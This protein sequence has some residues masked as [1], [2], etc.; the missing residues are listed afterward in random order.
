VRNETDRTDAVANITIA[1]N[2]TP[3]A[4][5]VI[6]TTGPEA[7]GLVN[8]F[9]VQ[10]AGPM[11][12]DFN[13]KSAPVGTLVTVTGTNLQP[14]AG[15]SA[16]VTLANQ[17]GGTL[18]GPVSGTTATSLSFVIPAGAAT[19]ALSVTVN[20]LSAST[21]VPMTIVP[22]STFT[23]SALPNPANL[24]LGQ[25][26]VYAVSLTSNGGFNQ[27]AALS[28]T[29]LPSGITAAF[30]PPQITGGQ[31]SVLSVTA[32]AGQPTGSTPL[33]VSAS[34]TVNGIAVVQSA[35][36]TLNVQPE[37]TSLLG[38]TVVSDALETPLAGV[39]ITMLGKDGNGNTTSCS[40]RTISD[41]AG[42]F[43]LTNLPAMCVGPQ[44]VGYD[45][46]TATS[47]SGKYAGV[48]LVYT[49][50]SGQA[51][52][53][54]VLIHLPRI[55]NQE[56]FLVQQ[57]E[58]VDQSYSYKTIPNLSVTAYAGTTF[59]MP[60]GTQPNP[61]P[62]TAVNVPVDRLPDIKPPV[63]TMI[64]AFI[65]AF[66]PAN[67]TTNQPVAVYYP[68]ELNEPAGMDMALLTLDPTH[69]AMVPYGTG[70]VSAD[71]SQIVP[72]L[73][74]AHSGHRY[75]LVHFD[76]HMPGYPPGNQLNPCVFCP[77]AKKGKPVDL[78]S[79]LEVINETDISFGG[80]RG[81]VSLVRTYRNA[82]NPQAT[83]YGPFGI[84][85]NHNYNYELGVVTASA[86]SVIPLILP[87]GNQLPFSKQGNGT[88]V[89]SSGIPSMAG[90]VMT[91][92]S[93]SNAVDLR[94]K[95][96]T[97]FRF[98]RIQTGV[99]FRNMLS[100][101]TDP[102]GNTIQILRN[103]FLVTD[104]ID[105][106][107]RDLNFSYNGD[108]FITQI[109]APDGLIVTYNYGSGGIFSERDVLRVV[110]HPDGTTTRY[111][112]DPSNNLT[113]VTDGRGVVIASNTYD[114]NNRVS[115]QRQANGGVLQFSYMVQNPTAPAFSP[116]L[117][118]TVTDALNKQTVYRFSPA[119]ALLGVTDPLG[120][121][122]VF[123]RDGSNNIIS[124]TGAAACE[125]CGSSGAGNQSFSYDGFGNL[126]SQTDALGNTTAFTYDP[127]F[128]KVTSIKDPLGDTTLFTYDFGGN[129][130]TQKDPNGNL[131]TYQYD[132]FGELKQA[133][134]PTNQTTFFSYDTFGNRI[135]IKD[136]LGD[137]TSFQY[138]AS[139]RLITT[140]DALNRRTQIAYDNADRIISQTNAQNAVTGFA[141]D[142][143][144]N[145]L[146]VTDPR[147]SQTTF[148]YDA[149]DGLFMRKDPLGR[150]DSR[151][152][153]LDEN[154]LQF[155]DRR[156]QTS[157]F[158]YDTT[159]RLTQEAYQDGTTV[160]RSY[161]ANNR[162]AGV[163]DSASGSFG[164]TYDSAGRVIGCTTPFGTMQY[165]RDSL[166]RATSRQVVGQPAVT[167]S[168]DKAGNLLT[169]ATPAASVTRT[170]EARNLLSTASRI[171]GVSSRYTYDQIGRLISLT[172]SGPGGILNTQT[173]SYDA[174]GNRQSATNTI[175]QTLV[176]PAVT[177]AS[178]DSDNE[179]N[180]FGPTSNIFDANGNLVSSTT[181]G[182]T[183]AYTWDARNR[184]AA[185]ST[186]TG[187]TTQFLYDFA[188]NLMQQADT[189]PTA[190]VTQTFLL[191]DLTN[192]AYVNRTD[193]DEY[194]VLAGQSIDD[195]LGVV[196]GSGQ[197]EY[198]LAD[199]LNSTVITADQAGAIK[200][201]FAYEP[202]GQT[203]ATNSTFPF[204]YTGRIPVSNLYY[205]RA[206]FYNPT[207]GRFISEEPTD[208]Q[209][210]LY[211]YVNGNPTSLT[212]PLGLFPIISNPTGTTVLS[213]G[214]R[215]SCPIGQSTFEDCKDE[216]IRKYFGSFAANT[217][218]PDLSLG[219]FV[220]ARRFR[221]Y[222]RTL[223]FT[224]GPKYV[225]AGF[226]YS[227][228]EAAA[229]A[230]EAGGAVVVGIP[231][232]IDFLATLHCLGR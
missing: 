37:T 41:A 94:W 222:V 73:D 71:G 226:A 160:A 9:T 67:A 75:G 173:Y 56:T 203:F 87:D 111:D 115:Q 66:Q 29:G 44:L 172:H 231:T 51:T 179:Q 178:Y 52:P 43:A 201:R 227:A 150:I 15:T 40:G 70:A 35:A 53:A 187:Q 204:Q 90:A 151:T 42:N 198:G 49:V 192:V 11:I 85:T 214:Y 10:G 108:N 38:R 86:V 136:P 30:N 195:H 13:P 165:I 28:V 6:M 74:P 167:Y 20:G 17:I 221:R 196:H 122:L 48:N 133:T 4:R 154:L 158:A 47:P 31:T 189:E 152:Y 232:F 18:A 169:A 207:T 61:F 21:A 103:G 140:Y 184:L 199:A 168:Y 153:D 96:G 107:G 100:S 72:D 57:N 104:I 81:T 119:G 114:G 126:L 208:V 101:I 166:G 112:Y 135:S 193:G 92:E 39:T 190:N 58:P 36:V 82:V 106:V 50:V 2:A 209:G 125:V 64:T 147:G 180:Q 117:A 185:A 144:G 159:N 170:Y 164:F 141:Y 224:A 194:F 217:L 68:N 155:K 97:I 216:F 181:S 54:P 76:W 200:G 206:R 55:D 228:S 213:G 65:V 132:Q 91:L 197:I 229:T 113:A 121:T 183:T 69:G 211:Q 138:D 161:D 5:T 22:A 218:V 128:N 99:T 212:D 177:P 1:P 33:T 34:A 46:T 8:G 225:I 182:V 118:T 223:P 210:D 191:D 109:T 176:T 146:L 139:G 19:G 175:A 220:D 130:Q 131:T 83:T 84:G 14:N 62:L 219:S 98:V 78:S 116:V 12:T 7:A 129:L 88:F 171:N 134:D 25:S 80:S 142:Q 127:T 156:G 23:L 186:S 27:L 77:I 143:V 163:T 79:G 45:G 95:D 60:D 174:V 162:L 32:P 148:T 120:Q 137:V 145:L 215:L 105:P 205:Y 110:T 89:N 202:F 123:N 102:N 16:Q 157:T 230:V 26:T 124:I 149:M 188:G 59:T 93:S 24:I 3:G 63:P